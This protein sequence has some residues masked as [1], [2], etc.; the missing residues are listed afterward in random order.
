MGDTTIVRGE[1]VEQGLGA[2]VEVLPGKALPPPLMADPT[3]PVST[4]R[5]RG[6]G[7]ALVLHLGALAVTIAWLVS[8]ASYVG[9]NIGWE[10]VTALQPQELGGLASMAL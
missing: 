9:N 4:P 7:L 3:P 8:C 2:L 6:N 5:K 1:T 10:N